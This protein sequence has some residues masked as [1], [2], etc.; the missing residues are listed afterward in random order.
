MDRSEI[1]QRM[2]EAD[3]EL[4]EMALEALNRCHQAGAKVDDLQFIGWLAGCSDW[5]PNERRT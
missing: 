3:K 2:A 4:Q 5:K 1:D